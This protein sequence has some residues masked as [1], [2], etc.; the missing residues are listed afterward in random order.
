[1]ELPRKQLE[2][3]VTRSAADPAQNPCPDGWLE[4]TKGVNAAVDN[5]EAHP[6]ASATTV[7][8]APAAESPLSGAVA[9]GA[10]GPST[11]F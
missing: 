4:A 7:A 5:A 9:R 1:M 2:S 11:R 8:G 10:D 6:G 3:V